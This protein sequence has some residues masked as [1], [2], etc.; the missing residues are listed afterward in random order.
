MAPVPHE[1]RMIGETE[2]NRRTGFPGRKGPLCPRFVR[3][4][5]RRTF[6]K[7]P[8]VLRVTAAEKNGRPIGAGAIARGLIRRVFFRTGG[9]SIRIDRKAAGSYGFVRARPL[10]QGL[11]GSIPSGA[12]IKAGGIRNA[13]S[14]IKSCR[15]PFA[16]KQQISVHLLRVKK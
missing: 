13:P 14:A 3:A 16:F 6:S 1:V 9:R 12:L 8:S 15:N 4:L 5:I 7:K 2:F 11:T 10:S